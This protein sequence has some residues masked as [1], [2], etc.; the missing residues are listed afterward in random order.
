MFSYLKGYQWR[1]VKSYNFSAP[2]GK[3]T[4][5]KVVGFERGNAITTDPKD[6]PDI[7]FRTNSEA[8]RADAAKKAK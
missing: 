6:R 3:V 7:D 4:S 8:D 1:V 2:E 5:I